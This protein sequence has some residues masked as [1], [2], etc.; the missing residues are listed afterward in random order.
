MKRFVEDSG[1]INGC[2]IMW[3]NVAESRVLKG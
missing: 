2:N 3:G 1:K